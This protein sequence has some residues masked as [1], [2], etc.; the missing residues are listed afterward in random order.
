MP[1]ISDIHGREVL[2]SRGN[3][4]IEV[5][6]RL[7][8]GAQGRA[9]VPSGASTGDHEAVE[10]RDGDAKRY[11][12]KGV[13]KAVSHVNGELAQAVTGRD[14]LDQAGLDEAMIALDGTENKGRLGANA[15][16][17]VSLA[18]AHAAAR[19]TDQPLYAYLAEGADSFTLPIPMMNIINGGSHADNNVDIQE[20]M[21]FP[22]GAT[23]FSEALQ[24]GVETFHHLKTVL[25]GKG[26]TT[27]VGDEGGFAPNL[28]SNEEAIEIILEAVQ[29]TGYTPGKQLYLALDAAASEFYDR[30]TRRYNLA[31]EGKVLDAE[32]LIGV[33]EGWINSYPIISLEDGLDE[34]DWDNWQVLQQRLGAKVQIVGDDL[35]VTSPQRLQR[36]IDERSMNAILIKLNQVGSVTETLRT[37]D[38]A[39]TAGYG[40]VISHRSGETEDVSIADLAVATGVGQIK[41]GSA[42]RTD[43]IAKYNQLLRIEEALGAR[44]RFPGKEV[45]PMFQNNGEQTP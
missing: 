1:T 4:T 36:A 23:S 21:I 27:S 20:F 7:S 38:L 11:L 40:A 15:I 31:S 35:T 5:E 42:S 13:L 34:D 39:R 25:K 8:D 10:R 2:D 18:V 37:I 44:A 19:S 41:T 43:R 30:N 6:A 29:R 14:A 16:L 12:G 28:R 24:M 3:P 45:F 22:V 32:E 17:G 33:Y 9:I 26:L